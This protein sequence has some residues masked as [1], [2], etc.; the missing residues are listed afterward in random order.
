VVS[1]TSR[2]LYSRGKS[3]R[4]PLHKRL[5]GRHSR[6]RRRGEK[7]I[8]DP[9]GIGTPSQ[10]LYGLRYPDARPL[11]I[12][13]TKKASLCTD[14][15]PRIRIQKWRSMVSFMVWPLQPLRKSSY[16]VLGGTHSRSESCGKEKNSC[17][18][19]ELNLER[20]ACTQSLNWLSY[21]AH[22]VLHYCWLCL[23][24]HVLFIQAC[25]NLDYSTCLKTPLSHFFSAHGTLNPHVY[26][27]LF[28]TSHT[29][30]RL[31][32]TRD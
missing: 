32:S 22:G 29:L 3:L 18:S 21:P 27:I 20:E 26:C 17:P 12:K 11:V 23:L 2:P 19:R 4:Y 30:M 5:D 1:F 14:T 13:N 7:K 15:N 24:Q 8:L 28:V 16:L 9:T 25:L 6:S 10:S 31:W